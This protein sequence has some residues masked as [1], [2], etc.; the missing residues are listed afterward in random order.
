VRSDFLE[1]NDIG[2]A[3]NSRFPAQDTAGRLTRMEKASGFGMTA[4]VVLLM[5]GA[6]ESKKRARLAAPFPAEISNMRNL[7]YVG[8]CASASF[9]LCAGFL[10][11]AAKERWHVEIVR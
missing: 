11:L 10:G 6:I 1:R 8:R 7:I 4:Q 2:L 9:R 3:M 5:D